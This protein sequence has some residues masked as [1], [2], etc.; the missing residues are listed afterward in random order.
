MDWFI[1]Y[2]MTK[3][4]ITITLGVEAISR[5]KSFQIKSWLKKL[6]EKVLN[7]V[8]TL[9]DGYKNEIITVRG[10]KIWSYEIEF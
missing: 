6:L 10:K 1:L 8:T 7:R 3:L 9:H 2:A 5:R 4:P